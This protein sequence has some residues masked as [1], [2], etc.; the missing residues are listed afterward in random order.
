MKKI[1]NVACELLDRH[2][3][4]RGDKAAIYYEGERISYRRL[5]EQVNRFGNILKDLE[6]QPGERI[7]INLDRP[8]IG[9]AVE[10]LRE[11]GYFL[12]GYVPRW[13]DTDGFLM[14]KILS[15]PDF[16]TIALY[17][18]KAREIKRHVQADWERATKQ[19][20]G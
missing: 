6:V 5:H 10:R 11:K 1:Y 15:E 19:A 16:S 12:G 20:H 14:Q 2:I 9:D 3:I 13:F 17:S 4:S 8:W 18:E 7:L